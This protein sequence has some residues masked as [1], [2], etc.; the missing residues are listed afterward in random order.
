MDGDGV[1]ETRTLLALAT[2]AVTARLLVTTISGT[3]VY[4][5]LMVT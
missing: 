5:A 4:G 3:P 2:A 1:Q